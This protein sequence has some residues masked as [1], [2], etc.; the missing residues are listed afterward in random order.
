VLLLVG[1]SFFIED[2][3]LLIDILFGEKKLNHTVK[4]I[5]RIFNKDTDN[6]PDNSSNFV[7][8]IQSCV[9]V[10]ADAS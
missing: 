2:I 8:L 10:Y 4:K 5:Q 6:E 9:G 3:F 7:W 1:F